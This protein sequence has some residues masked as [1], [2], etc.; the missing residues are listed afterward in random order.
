MRKPRLVEHRARHALEVLQAG[1]SGEEAM[2]FQRRFIR[3]QVSD[4]LSRIAWSK[5]DGLDR[6]LRVSSATV[7]CGSG[8]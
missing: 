7:R 1:K 6:R 2:L 4:Q 8:S 3:E 5:D